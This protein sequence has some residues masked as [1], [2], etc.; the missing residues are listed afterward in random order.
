[1]CVGNVT[2]SKGSGNRS[3]ANFIFVRIRF[4]IVME[5]SSEKKGSFVID[6][7]TVR[8]FRRLSLGLMLSIVSVVLFVAVPL[9]P[10]NVGLILLAPLAIVYVASV[11]TRGSGWRLLGFST[12][13][14]AVEVCAIFIV[15]FPFWQAFLGSLRGLLTGLSEGLIFLFP[16]AFWA[17][18]TFLEN[19][20][21][22][23]LEKKFAL[24]LMS[25]RILSTLGIIVYALAYGYGLFTR[26]YLESLYSLMVFPF[27][28]GVFASPFLV[29]CSLILIVKLIKARVLVPKIV[30]NGFNSD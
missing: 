2:P 27:V 25:V 18:Y 14:R 15:L 13:Q 11:Y 20:S 8:S 5:S 1:M 3:G 4:M 30:K 6:A 29:L 9:L 19:R 23:E 24:K 28:Y 16:L 21:F 12:T 7:Q 10:W 22:R 26:T 17:F